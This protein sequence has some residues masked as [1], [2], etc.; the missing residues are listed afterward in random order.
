M[1]LWF[2]A[3]VFKLQK[4]HS[5]DYNGMPFNSFWKC[6]IHTAVDALGIHKL[7]GQVCHKDIFCKNSFCLAYTLEATYHHGTIYIY[8]DGI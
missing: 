2:K 5:S 7:Y 6:N 1:S 4:G 8:N 3:D